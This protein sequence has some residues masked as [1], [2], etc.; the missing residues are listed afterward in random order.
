MYNLP[1]SPKFRDG[2][3]NDSDD[4]DDDGYAALPIC[5]CVCVSVRACARANF[6]NAGEQ[7]QTLLFEME[8]PLLAT[9]SGKVLV[10]FPLSKIDITPI[11]IFRSMAQQPHW[12]RVYSL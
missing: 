12:A 9:D 2:D 11:L 10:Y 8:N 1:S 7:N 4:D 5:V 6:G 3:T